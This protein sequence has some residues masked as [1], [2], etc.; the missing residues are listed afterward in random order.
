MATSP[1]PFRLARSMA[2][3]GQSTLREV[4]GL[5]SRPGILSLAVGLPAPELFPMEGIARA[6]AS[7]LPSR[8][9]SV[10]YGIPHEPL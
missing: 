8:P 5:V 6:A 3:M 4:L 10:Q 1:E 9:E 2:S 7:L